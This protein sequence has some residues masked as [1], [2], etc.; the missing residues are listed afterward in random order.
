LKAA[1][2]LTIDLAGIAGIGHLVGAV[3]VA[4]MIYGYFR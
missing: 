2:R 4:W 1:E 3:I